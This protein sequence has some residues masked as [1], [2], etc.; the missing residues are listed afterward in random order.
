VEE[1]K[2]ADLLQKHPALFIMAGM[3]ALAVVD[4]RPM[5]ATC[6]RC[7]IRFDAEGVARD[8]AGIGKTAFCSSC[9]STFGPGRTNAAW[10]GKGSCGSAPFGPQTKR[11]K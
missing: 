11:R 5:R 4:A 8:R 3:L 2:L 10:R 9:W 6:G 1:E 7:G